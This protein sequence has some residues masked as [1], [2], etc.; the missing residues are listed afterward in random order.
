MKRPNLFVFAID[1][2][3]P[4]LLFKWAGEGALPNIAGIKQRGFWG[5]TGGADLTNEHGAFVSLFSGVSCAEHGYYYSRQLRPGTY[6]LFTTT[7]RDAGT[8]P[9][10]HHLRGTD[11]RVAVIDMPDSMT[12]DRLEGLQLCNWAS[13]NPRLPA[14][15]EPPEIL[16]QARK[17]FGP[18]VPVSEDPDATVEGDRRLLRRM[19]ERIG[20]KG[21]L[22]RHLLG[23]EEFDLV[24]I[25][26]GESHDAAHQFWP[27][28]AGRMSG[29][30]DLAGGLKAVYC[31]IDRELGKLLELMPENSNCFVV[32]SVGIQEQYP[33]FHVMEDFC[34]KLGYQAA[35][36]AG[37]P[38]LRPMD[39]IRRALPESWRVAVSRHFSRA[40]RE[41][42]LADQFRART[43]WSRTTVFAIP[44]SFTGLLRVNLHG[45]EPRGTV[46]PGTEYHRLLERVVEDLHRLVDPVTGEAAVEDA[47]ITAER[48]GGGPPPS[49]PDIFVVFKPGRHFMSRLQHP[50]AE[51][52]QEV[53]EFSRDTHHS[54]HGFVAGA[55][56]DV[57]PHGEPGEIPVLSLAP[58]FLSLMGSTIP[59]SMHGV[60]CP[61]VVAENA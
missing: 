37:R 23:D 7:A 47:V 20:K 58:M 61:E 36:P 26:F 53:P 42:L 16:D 3:D 31:A 59:A 32:S 51:L 8:R 14:S 10:W 27:Y 5:R 43:D 50:R 45:R 2:G 52:S 17:A 15:A 41:R 28:L 60:S 54:R 44:S 57:T 39:L 1:A 12:V 34:R 35:P 25:G 6:D 56:P 21:E 9:F 40:T 46:E 11:A 55:G 18:V 33:I 19:L 22:C 13:H 30:D 29:G 24:A 49:L 38:T 4:D 48:F